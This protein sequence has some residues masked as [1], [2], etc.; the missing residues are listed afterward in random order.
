MIRLR[1][2][3]PVTLLLTATAPH[4]VAQ[5]NMCPQ[6]PCAHPAGGPRY[7]TTTV[8]TIRGTIVRIDT[9]NA[10]GGF[11]GGVHLLLKAGAETLSVHLGPAWYLAEQPLKLAAGD[12]IDIRGSRITVNGSPALIAAEVRRG[13][14]AL[15]LRDKNGVP[16]WSGRYSGHMPMQCCP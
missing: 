14:E 5:G 13:D 7:D 1:L 12:V 8:Q 2:L 16:T 3:A 11:Q 6:P 4:A 10:R 15:V 9:A